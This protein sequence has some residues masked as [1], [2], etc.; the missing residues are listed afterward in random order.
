MPIMIRGYGWL[1]FR[2]KDAGLGLAKAGDTLYV[3]SSFFDINAPSGSTEKIALPAVSV[4]KSYKL[5]WNCNLRGEQQEGYFATGWLQ[6]HSNG[7]ATRNRTLFP[8]IHGDP[9][10]DTVDINY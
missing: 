4:T 10:V 9:V 7:T 2:I 6:A 3:T 8:K 1:V 5:F